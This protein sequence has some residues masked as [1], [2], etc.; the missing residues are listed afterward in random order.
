MSSSRPF[1]EK[2][3]HRRPTAPFLAFGARLQHGDLHATLPG[4][5]SCA[6]VAGIG[7][8]H[9]SESR[10]GREDT[11]EPVASVI[12]PV[13]YHDHTRV[14]RKAHSNSASVVQRDPMSPTRHRGHG[15]E[16]RPVADRVG[17]VFHAFCLSV[18]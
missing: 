12:G 7:V 17:A 9:N 18:G 2:K 3:G 8:S 16:E 5:F 11:L 6:V 10:I 4:A 14:L 13:G 1:R 15:V